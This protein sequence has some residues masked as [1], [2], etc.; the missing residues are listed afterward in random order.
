VKDAKEVGVK[1]AAEETFSHRTTT[2]IAYARNVLYTCI[3]IARTFFGHARVIVV[4]PPMD[5]QANALGLRS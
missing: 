3:A 2:S 1:D 5:D 4:K